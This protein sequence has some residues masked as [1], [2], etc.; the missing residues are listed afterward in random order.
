MECKQISETLIDY[1][2][3]NVPRDVSLEIENHLPTCERC[4]EEYRTLSEAVS[5]ISEESDHI[6]VPNDFLSNVESRLPERP[7][8]QNRTFSKTRGWGITL[9]AAAVAFLLIVSS[10]GT[11]GLSSL[12]KWFGSPSAEDVLLDSI[13][14]KGYGERV[15]ITAVDQGIQVTITEVVADE[16]QIV[17][18][19]EI[20]DLEGQ[21]EVD[22]SFTNVWVS[23]QE[24]LLMPEGG[25]EYFDRHMSVMAYQHLET[26]KDSVT[27]G[28]MVF[29]AT[30]RESGELQ[31]IIDKLV[32][33]APDWNADDEYMVGNV[34]GET[35]EQF[36]VT[37]EWTLNVPFTQHPVKTY[38]VHDDPVEIYDG[39]ASAHVKKVEVGPTNTFVHMNLSRTE[40][41]GGNN[42][43]LQVDSLRINGEKDFYQ[44]IL[45]PVGTR[46]A[47]GTSDL[48]VFETIYLEEVDQLEVIFN[49]ASIFVEDYHFVPV[50]SDNMIFDY[51][52]TNFTISMMEVGETYTT[53]Q[54]TEDYYPEREHD[55]TYIDVAI[56]G[57]SLSMNPSSFIVVDP[58]GRR[59]ET[60]DYP[61][62]AE[63][64]GAEIYSV[65]HI[66]R[67]SNDYFFQKEDVELE[68][69]MIAGYSNQTY[70]VERV[71]LQDL[72]IEND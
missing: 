12:T 43:Y 51:N 47:F 36:S 29:P 41:S 14:E 13:I 69:V 17:L 54:V 35:E 67:V 19:Y 30:E 2:D 26:E 39:E 64:D 37:G 28:K 27:R 60:N 50:D 72:R 62:P 20:K 3:G 9:A 61:D 38:T 32:E 8:Q 65:E 70:K 49:L 4:S 44:D 33:P 1:I 10:M 15:E 68:S 45:R 7:T 25:I 53:I 42:P 55:I 11:D 52:G 59:H 5:S 40:E 48:L 22:F 34:A 71:I 56:N 6:S 46:Y 24:E 21:Q 18:Y 57:H 23:N 66:L 58:D 16:M 31:L 63:L